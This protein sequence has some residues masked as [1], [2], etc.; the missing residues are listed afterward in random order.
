MF[1]TYHVM[2]SLPLA[3]VQTDRR[4]GELADHIHL[5]AGVAAD[6]AAA[7]AEGTAGAAA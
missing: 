5:R 2:R 3:S 7:A 4:A 6:H 1:V